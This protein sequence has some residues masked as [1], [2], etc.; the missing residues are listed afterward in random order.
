MADEAARLRAQI[1]SYRH[2][3][4]NIAPPAATWQA[5]IQEVPHLQTPLSSEEL[6]DAEAA[7]ED[8][9][10]ERL[11]AR[12]A[13][14]RDV[15]S[16]LPNT[17]RVPL[18]IERS[19][20]GLLPMQRS[21]RSEFC[22]HVDRS[23]LLEQANAS[24]SLRRPRRQKQ[25]RELKEADKTEKKRSMEVEAAKRKRREDFLSAL[26]QH[27]DEF[28][29]FHR[30]ARR[31]AVRLGKAVLLHFEMERRKGKRDNE[32]AQRERLKALKENNMEEYMKLVS[33]SKNE[34]ITQLLQE[35]DNYLAELG[36]KVQQQKVD[37]K[38][39]V[40]K[41]K[42]VG[43]EGSSGAA[44][45]EEDDDDDDAAMA[46]AA[47]GGEGESAADKY[48]ERSAYYKLA[49]TVGESIDV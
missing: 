21:L 32:K 37:V 34:R 30:D 33:D 39:N 15:P 14:L 23:S 26:A 13:E 9:I 25:Q 12:Q 7:A 29:S 38:K 48:S 42:L 44:G 11:R 20:P 31:G 36:A 45:A 49:H 16:D 17:V 43:G 22:S 3:V 5:S 2:L 41:A 4:R 6:L 18:V 40:K 19:M 1:A 46:A 24:F 28:K 47:K 35:T 10:L 8:Q 27:T